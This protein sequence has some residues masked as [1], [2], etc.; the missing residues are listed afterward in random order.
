[1]SRNASRTARRLSTVAVLTAAAAALPLV[2]AATASAAVAPAASAT[3]AASAT[4][5][6]PTA[7]HSF[8]LSTHTVAFGAK[9]L[10][11]AATKKVTFKNTGTKALHPVQVL[12]APASVS[13]SA[14]T[15]AAKS[16][17]AGGSCAY[18]VRFAPTT[19]GPVSGTLQV[20]TTEGTPAQDVAISGTGVQQLMEHYFYQ[21]TFTNPP[22]INGVAAPQSF[23]GE[24]RAPAGTYTTGQTIAVYD[25]TGLNQIGTYRIGAVDNTVPLDSTLN[26]V[27]VDS[28]TWGTNTY[29]AATGLADRPGTTGLGSEAG[30]IAGLGLEGSAASFNDHQPAVVPHHF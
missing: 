5:A 20:L 23:I 14:N 9:N 10:G 1:M 7:A 30:S 29:T 22:V 3:S 13:L 2:N 28:Y 27:D 25:A 24:G 18:T 19:A 15:C 8:T 6:S 21:Y 12:S 4:A 11:T 26:Q 16:V 17:P